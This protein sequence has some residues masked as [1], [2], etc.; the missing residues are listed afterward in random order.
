MDYGSTCE[1]SIKS[2]GYHKLQN[3]LV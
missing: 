1:S 3:Y 2:P